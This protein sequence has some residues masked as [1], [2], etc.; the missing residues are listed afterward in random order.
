MGDQVLLSSL[1]RRK[2][3]GDDRHTVVTGADCEWE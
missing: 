3:L 2:K 1:V